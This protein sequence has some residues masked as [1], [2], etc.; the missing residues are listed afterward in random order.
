MIGQEIKM[1]D[2]ILPSDWP[3][4]NCSVIGHKFKMEDEK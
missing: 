2:E 3:V 1:A 4:L